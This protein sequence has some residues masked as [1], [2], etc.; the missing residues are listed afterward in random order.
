MFFRTP[1]DGRFWKTAQQNFNE[2]TDQKKKFAYALRMG[3]LN[4]KLKRIEENASV[5][6]LL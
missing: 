3:L 2:F 6:V 5:G 1:L 4:K